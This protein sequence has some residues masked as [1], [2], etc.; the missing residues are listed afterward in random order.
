MKLLTIC[1]GCNLQDRGCGGYKLPRISAHCS[2]ETLV[3]QERSHDEVSANIMN[4]M[5]SIL[6]D[7]DEQIQRLEQLQHLHSTW[8]KADLIAYY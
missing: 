3:Q 7:H 5:R 6:Q 1:H 8:S 4:L 2:C